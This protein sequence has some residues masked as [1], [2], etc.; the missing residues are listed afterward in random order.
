MHDNG[1][2]GVCGSLVLTQPARFHSA[3]KTKRGDRVWKTAENDLL[4]VWC[5]RDAS[6]TVSRV[7]PPKLST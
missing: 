6:N 4:A 5:K 2:D 3:N 7:L 1:A